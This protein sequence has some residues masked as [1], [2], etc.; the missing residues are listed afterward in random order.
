MARLNDLGTEEFFTT[1]VFVLFYRMA[2]GTSK[3]HMGPPDIGTV[4]AGVCSIF[5]FIFW[6]LTGTFPP[7]PS[8]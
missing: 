2:E 8:R 1:G 3:S 7:T 4:P 5:Y 6:A